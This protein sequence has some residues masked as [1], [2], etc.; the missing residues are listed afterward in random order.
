MNIFISQPMTGRDERILAQE[1]E[2]VVDSIKRRFKL[3]NISVV[4]GFYPNRSSLWCLGESIKELEKADLV[5]FVLG[6]ENARGCRIERAVC[7]E[8]DI[9]CIDWEYY[10]S[11]D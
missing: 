6:W 1:R 7:K 8:Y 9:P 10:G 4:G 11:E 2:H 3:D 5:V